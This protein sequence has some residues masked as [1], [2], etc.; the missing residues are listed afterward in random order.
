MRENITK[1]R[2]HFDHLHFT[3][4]TQTSHNVLHIT[5]PHFMAI[6]QAF[7]TNKTKNT[8]AL[9]LSYKRSQPRNSL[10]NRA[11]YFLGLSAQVRVITVQPETKLLALVAANTWNQ[12]EIFRHTN[13]HHQKW[14]HPSKVKDV[15]WGILLKVQFCTV[16]KKKKWGKNDIKIKHDLGSQKQKDPR[17]VK[18]GEG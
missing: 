17:R 10:W 18:K 14:H 12:Q 9:I 16:K 4:Q 3:E 13:E 6:T 7:Q 2:K 15:E 5:S 1:V 8:S 11:S